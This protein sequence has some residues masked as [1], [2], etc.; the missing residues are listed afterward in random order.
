MNG[1]IATEDNAASLNFPSVAYKIESAMSAAKPVGPG[2]KPN[3]IK[4]L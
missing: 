1:N 3:P 4:K 2:A